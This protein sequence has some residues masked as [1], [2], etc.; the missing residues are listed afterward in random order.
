MLQTVIVLT[1][2]SVGKLIK[3]RVLLDSASQRTFMTNQLAQK[4]KLPLSQKEHLSISIFGTQKATNI[5]AHV[6]SFNIVVSQCVETYYRD[7]YKEI[8]YQKMTY[9]F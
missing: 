1:Q 5:D 2:R 7:E 4:L 6:V 8:H 3:A 9:S